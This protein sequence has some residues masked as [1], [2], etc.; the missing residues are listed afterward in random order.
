MPRDDLPMQ[1]RGLEKLPPALVQLLKWLHAGQARLT[2]PQILVPMHFG[3]PFA[4]SW[5]KRMDL[6]THRPRL[7]SAMEP[8]KAFGKQSW[9]YAQKM[10]R[11]AANMLHTRFCTTCLLYAK[12]QLIPSSCMHHQTLILCPT[13]NCPWLMLQVSCLS[14]CIMLEH[15]YIPS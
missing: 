9:L 14:A 5:D 7:L 10:M 12:L 13:N 15:Q 6:N 4:T 8:S 1:S 3:K 2:T 11:S